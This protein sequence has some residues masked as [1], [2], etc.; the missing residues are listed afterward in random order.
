M[1][2][3]V[4]ADPGHALSV[5]LD[6]EPGGFRCWLQDSTGQV[7]ATQLRPGLRHEYGLSVAAVGFVSKGAQ[8]LGHRGRERDVPPTLPR[9]ESPP[10]AVVDLLAHEYPR[11]PAQL[12]VLPGQAD[13]LGD[14]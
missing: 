5:A 4:E 10:L 1:P 3:R 7:R 6:R 14:A 12:D 8:S 2:E 11:L 9:L 13:C